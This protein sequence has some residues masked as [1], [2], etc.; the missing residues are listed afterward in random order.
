MNAYILTLVSL[1]HRCE[2]SFE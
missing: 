2:L 1:V